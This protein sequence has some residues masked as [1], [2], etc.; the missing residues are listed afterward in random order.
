[1]QENEKTVLDKLNLLLA[2][3]EVKIS[4]IYPRNEAGE[5][6]TAHWVSITPNGAAPLWWYGSD[7]GLEKALDICVEKGKKLGFIT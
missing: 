7:C 2:F 4:L 5:R 3:S 1:M 6:T